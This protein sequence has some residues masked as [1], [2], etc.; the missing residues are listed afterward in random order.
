MGRKKIDIELLPAKKIQTTY[1][2]RK[3]GLI[4][5]AKELGILCGNQV[6]MI[7]FN[8]SGSDVEA[9]ATNGDVM[10]I[11]QRF[12]DFRQFHPQQVQSV[13]V[14]STGAPFNHPQAPQ[15]STLGQLQPTGSAS[16][17]PVHDVLVQSMASTSEAQI[18]GPG[19][20]PNIKL[21][22]RGGHY[23]EYGAFKGA[24]LGLQPRMGRFVPL[25]ARIG[26]GGCRV[27]QG[28]LPELHR[29]TGLRADQCA[30]SGWDRRSHFQ[31]QLPVLQY[32]MRHA[33]ARCEYSVRFWA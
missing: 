11:L 10:D 28:H 15:D 19:K 23:N 7:A 18:V 3:V 9:V 25:C 30:Q 14:S 12:L 13:Q 22:S 1:S 2:K 29:T 16:N 6:V 8:P 24:R 21:A 5:K 33:A 32:A 20:Q 31:G 26:W 4:N 27:F 17:T